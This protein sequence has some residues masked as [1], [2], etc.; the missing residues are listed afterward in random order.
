MPMRAVAE[1]AATV[2]VVADFTAAAVAMWDVH[3]P[4]IR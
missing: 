2:V 4:R 3:I 1:V